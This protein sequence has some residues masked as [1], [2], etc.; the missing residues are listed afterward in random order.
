MLP[1]GNDRFA[2]VGVSIGTARF[3]GNGESLDQ[4]IIAADKAMYSVKD[5]NKR[6]NQLINE[7]IEDL[8]QPSAENNLQNLPEEHQPDNGFVVEVDES[9]IISTAI[10]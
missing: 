5:S 6:K 10:N 4:V 3:P 1:V 7:N 2:Q 9:H 8:K